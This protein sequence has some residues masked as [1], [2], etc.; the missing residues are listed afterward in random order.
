MKR[1]GISITVEAGATILQTITSS[2]QPR[3][4]KKSRRWRKMGN[5]RLAPISLAD[6]FTSSGSELSAG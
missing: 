1:Q 4:D 5:T 3:L 6:L 2:R